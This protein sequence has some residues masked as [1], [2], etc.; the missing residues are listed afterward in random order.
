MNQE[1]QL[2]MEQKLLSFFAS[3]YANYIDTLGCDYQ[4]ELELNNAYLLNI[5]ATLLNV[6]Q[7]AEDEIN[8]FFDKIKAE[9]MDFSIEKCKEFMALSLDERTS[10]L[11][12]SSHDEI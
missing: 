5:K 6:G 11:L 4:N 7:G 8:Q 9:D 10:R 12:E 2:D 3:S 1:Q